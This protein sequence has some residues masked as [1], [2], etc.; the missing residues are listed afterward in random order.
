MNTQSVSSQ[1][2][3]GISYP[4]L[5]ISSYVNKQE[6]KSEIRCVKQT[7]D[8]DQQ[9]IVFTEKA[10]DRKLLSRE[11]D[12]SKGCTKCANIE[13]SVENIDR[14]KVYYCDGSV[15]LYA[16]VVVGVLGLVGNMLISLRK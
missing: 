5:L 8:K 4:T 13:P 2:N 9:E 11:V 6:V 15:C 7:V 14:K 10:N 1:K 12:D 3:E 16:G